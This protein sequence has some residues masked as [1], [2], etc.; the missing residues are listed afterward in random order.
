MGD[1]PQTG[2]DSDTFRPIIAPSARWDEEAEPTSPLASMWLAVSVVLGALA[3]ICIIAWVYVEDHPRVS[4]AARQSTSVAAK[5]AKAPRPVPSASAAP[6]QP[7]A[8]GGFVA[9]VG[10]AGARVLDGDKIV[11]TVPMLHATSAGP[12]VI[13][14]RAVGSD[15]TQTFNVE[16]RAHETAN[17]IVSPDNDKSRSKRRVPGTKG[18]S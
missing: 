14:V 13:R 18:R 4:V 17:L 1:F 16:V 6:Q 10:P 8:G 9:I 3:G 15:K 5:P 11:G 2:R 7:D 12:H